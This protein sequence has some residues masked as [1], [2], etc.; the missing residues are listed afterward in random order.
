MNGME[1]WKQTHGIRVY[2][3]YPLFCAKRELKIENRTLAEIQQILS[4]TLF[5]KT[6]IFQTMT[7]DFQQNKI[8]VSPKQLHLFDL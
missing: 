4:V 5:E 1:A 3:T 6:P 7:P 8:D 2:W